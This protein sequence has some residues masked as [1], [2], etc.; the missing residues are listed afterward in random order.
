VSIESNG[1]E[2]D[3]FEADDKAI[4]PKPLAV[5]VNGYSASA[6][7]I[8]AAALSESGTG[9]LVGTKTFGKGVV[10]DVTRFPDGSAIKITTGRYFT[11]LNHDINGHGIIPAVVVEENPKAIFGKP[12][13]D[14]Q[15]SRALEVVE[16]QLPLKGV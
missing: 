5:L 15:L 4:A 8:T 16:R 14:A 7:E 1:G 6:S 2:I 13:Q 3:T 10:Q 9:V 11:P 12:D